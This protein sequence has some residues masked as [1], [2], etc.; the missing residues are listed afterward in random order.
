M[1]DRKTLLE[2]AKKLKWFHA[3]DF[4]DCQSPGRFTP[5]MPQ[6]RTLYGVM[7][8]LCEIDLTDLVCLDIG[9]A[10]GLVA[11]NMA[12]RGAARVVATD[13]PDRPSF[14]TARQLLDLNVELYPDTSFENIVDK[15]GEHVFDVVVCA[16]VMYHMLNP[17]DSIIKA[18]K[19]LKRNGL[20]IFQTRYHPEDIGA[21]LDFNLVSSRLNQ[22]HVYW[23]PSKTAVTGMLTL[24]GFDLLGVRT[25]TKHHFIAMIARNVKLEEIANAP[26]LILQQHEARIRDAEF[27]CKLP[28][29]TSL[30]AYHAYAFDIVIDDLKY[31]PNFPPHP[32]QPKPVIGLSHHKHAAGAAKS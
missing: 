27:P 32:S 17:F 28:E 5:G 12:M 29:E 10:D 7:D 8:M 1:T 30:A 24:G 16:G 22:I 26:E 19:L 15:L 31:K 14:N 6:N 9:T 13:I 11:F 20:L 2:Q 21:T 4:G 18:R 3:I 25:G 23:V